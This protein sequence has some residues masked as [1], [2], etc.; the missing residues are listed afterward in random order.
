M[1]FTML[2]PAAALYLLLFIMS[3]SA[4]TSALPHS[5]FSHTIRSLQPQYVHP[6]FHLLPRSWR[7]AQPVEKRTTRLHRRGLPGAVYICTRENFRGDCA[8]TMP[9]NKCHIP[10]TGDNS[11]ES[12]G[13]DPG[14]YC[15]LWEKATCSGNQIATLRFPGLAT[16]VPDFGG[17]RCY[18]D[19]KNNNTMNANGTII[20]NGALAGN[21]ILAPGQKDVD[22]RLSGGVGSLESKRLKEVLAEFDKDGFK[23]GMIGLKKGHYY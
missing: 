4:P 2:I 16:Q 11:P 12:V 5:R 23:E 6:T 9:D 14:G 17:I 20:N 18:A 10:G 1:R 3:I 19:S 8:W 15:I 13:P 22:P 7:R 21:G